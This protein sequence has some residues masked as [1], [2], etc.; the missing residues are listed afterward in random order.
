VI[1]LLVVLAPSAVCRAADGQR[2]V[3]GHIGIATPFV[4][5]AKKTTSIADQFTLL[6]P[7]GIGFRK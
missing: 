7:I 6:N 4:T 1:P 2:D 3:E 5:V